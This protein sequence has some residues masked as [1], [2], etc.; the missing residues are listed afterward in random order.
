MTKSTRSFS[1]F[2]RS[3]NA[4]QNRYSGS[5]VASLSGSVSGSGNEYD[6]VL[7]K[8]AA[9]YAYELAA[10][11]APASPVAPAPKSNR[12]STMN[13]S[14]SRNGSL[15]S[16]G[17]D[18]EVGGFK[19]SSTMT[20]GSYMSRR[21]TISGSLRSTSNNFAPAGS[22]GYS[23]EKVSGSGH[24]NRV[25]SSKT[26]LSRA[27]ST[28]ANYYGFR[29]NESGTTMNGNESSRYTSYGNDSQYAAA[30]ASSASTRSHS[31][32]RRGYELPESDAK[33]G[34]K[35]RKKL[36][37]KAV[38][39][40]KSLRNSNISSAFNQSRA[41]LK[42]MK[43]IFS[44]G[45]KS[46]SQD[47]TLDSKVY[48]GRTRSTYGMARRSMISTG[49]NSGID[50]LM[51]HSED[52]H[53]PPQ[54]V[55]SRQAYYRPVSRAST[56]DLD[57]SPRY[58]CY[59]SNY[60]PNV[61][62]VTPVL[63]DKTNN[64]FI[65]EPM[66][67]AS[68]TSSYA[69][70][71][72]YMTSP[73]SG[74]TS[75]TSTAAVPSTA[76]ATNSTAKFFSKPLTRPIA[77]ERVY[78]A[79]MHQIRN[80]SSNPSIDNIDHRSPLAPSSTAIAAASTATRLRENQ[81][82]LHYSSLMSD[83]V[84]PASMETTGRQTLRDITDTSHASSRRVSIVTGN[85][86]N[87]FSTIRIIHNEPRPTAAGAFDRQ[88]LQQTGSSRQRMASENINTQN[89]IT[90]NDR[91]HRFV[92]STSTGSTSAALPPPPASTSPPSS[93][94]RHPI[95]MSPQMTGA[96][97]TSWANMNP[98]ESDTSSQTEMYRSSRRSQEIS[99]FFPYY[100]VS[101][102]TTSN[103]TKS[104]W[105]DWQSGNSITDNVH[106]ENR[107]IV[108]MDI[109]SDDESG[110]VIFRG[111]GSDKQPEIDRSAARTTSDT[112]TTIRNS[113]RQTDYHD[114]ISD[115]VNYQFGPSW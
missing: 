28:P 52:I 32:L 19:R 34:S 1:S 38:A 94:A 39:S 79:L 68:R 61:S 49:R 107:G 110:S 97:A 3:N 46:S 50:D 115:A 21:N 73:T 66:W 13:Y 113:H 44:F 82:N 53:I 93:T 27:N 23:G 6:T 83:R 114:S 77:P 90:L 92:S 86:G 96:T 37:K 71:D 16:V 54:Q 75:A 9:R 43:K 57:Y 58:D 5:T 67:S 87:G 103:N 109:A 99:T 70:T 95:P 40:I 105:R 84:A 80:G 29:A 42:G 8:A 55:M 63:K 25:F 41:I 11:S 64:N 36:E 26:S 35:L 18:G 59:A 51:V 20:S 12:S 88:Q 48:G 7:S 14:L 47:T 76:S 69:S 30:A 72:R 104:K 111:G 108:T 10:A 81:Q 22:V 112:D 56:T 2:R 17:R 15:R 33:N 98:S 24:D 4:Q 89:S 65:I 106:S 78:S 62:P 100:G 74:M 85:D 60:S 102:R 91:I 101:R 45:H 31:F